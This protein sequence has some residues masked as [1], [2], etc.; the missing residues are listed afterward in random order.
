MDPDEFE[1]DIHTMWSV[2]Y[3]LT[4]IFKTPDFMG[5]LRVT[6]K[7][8]AKVES[9]KGNTR[10]VQIL[11]NRGLKPRHYNMMTQVMLELNSKI[12]IKIK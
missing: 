9:L 6:F 3:K 7:L 10:L 12:I 5:P 8:K 1:Q 4:K 11:T 2:S